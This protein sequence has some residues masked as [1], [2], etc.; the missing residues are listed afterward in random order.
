MSS[1]FITDEMVSKLTVSG[2]PEDCIKKIKMF[3]E[4]GATSVMVRHTMENEDEWVNFLRTI[5]DHVIPAF[6]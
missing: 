2:T 1:G 5:I 6:R 3:E 4:R